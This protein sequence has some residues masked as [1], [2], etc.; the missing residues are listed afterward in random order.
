MVPKSTFQLH[1]DKYV[2]PHPSF[3]THK[4][5]TKEQGTTLKLIELL[6][7]TSLNGSFSQRKNKINLLSPLASSPFCKAEWK[8]RLGIAMFCN[9]M[10]LMLLVQFVLGFETK[11]LLQLISSSHY[12][13]HP[14]LPLHTPYKT[15]LSYEGKNGHYSRCMRPSVGLIYASDLGWQRRTPSS[16]RTS[17]SA[18][19]SLSYE[20]IKSARPRLTET[21]HRGMSV[22]SS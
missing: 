13:A 16:L 9:Y 17:P 3:E 22:Q 1:H 10:M 19:E 20:F 21:L 6:G 7:L 12:L 18:R 5:A 8:L 2:P 4:G 14:S 11:H 15:P